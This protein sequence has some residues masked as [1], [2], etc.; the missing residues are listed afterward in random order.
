[1]KS[2]LELSSVKVFRYF[3]ESENYCSLDLPIYIDFKPVLDY[4]ENKVG[5]LAFKDILKDQNKK[6]SDYEEVNHKILVKKDA[7]FTFRPIQIANPYLYYLLVKEITN[8]GNWKELK[9]RFKDFQRPEIEV[10]SIP[11]VKGDADKSHRS[12][13]VSSWWEKMEQRSIELSL[14]Y[15]YLFVTDITNCYPSI[16]THTIAWALMGKDV[17]KIKRDKGGLLGNTIDKYI[18][19]MQYCQTNGLPQGSVLFDFI[20]EMVL[21]YADMNL[22]N[23]LAAEG[24]ADYKIL[25]YRDDYRIFSNSKENLER[26][27][28]RLQEVLSDLNLQLNAKKTFLTEEVVQAS[29]KPDKVAYVTGIPLYKRTGKRITTTASSLQQEALYIHQFAK[30]YP[31]SGTLMKLLTTFSQRLTAKKK[32]LSEKDVDVMIA[33]FAEVAL[34]SPKSYKLLLHLISV[35]INKLPTTDKREKVVQAIYNKFK[36]IPNI[37][38][39]QIWMQHI[40]YKMPNGIPYTE[41]LCSIV[42]GEPNVSLW[43]NDWVKDDLKIG[44]PQYSICTNWLR[45]NFTPIIDIDEVSLFD[46]Y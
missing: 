15:K 1:M 13:S 36:E 11:Y 21:G 19:G 26:I 24:I 3:M 4:V 30:E 31:N 9:K 27:A 32:K 33:I 5:T 45:D 37:G 10:S 39:L 18:Q 38:E 16:Y 8:K 43:N 34:G 23:Q 46:V 25:R 35:L 40:T 44:F 17:A 28:F 14:S 20:A 41:K 29:I 12:A 22:A 7:K 6:P 42:A 2:I